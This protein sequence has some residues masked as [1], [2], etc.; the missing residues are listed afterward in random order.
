MAAHGTVP[1]APQA[2]SST[3][4][5]LGI[6]FHDEGDGDEDATALE[7][8]SAEDF[9]QMIDSAEATIQEQTLTDEDLAKLLDQHATLEPTSSARSRSAPSQNGVPGSGHGPRGVEEAMLDTVALDHSPPRQAQHRDGTGA[10]DGK[11]QRARDVEA[12]SGSGKP[13]QQV[14]PPP[15]ELRQPTAKQQQQQQQPPPRYSQMQQ[16]RRSTLDGPRTVGERGD[17]GD[18]LQDLADAFDAGTDAVMELFDEVKQNLAEYNALE[19]T[20]VFGKSD[21]RLGMR[22]ERRPTD[23]ACEVTFV[24]QDMAA[25][26]LGLQVDDI[27]VAVN[28]RPTPTFDHAM[29]FLSHRPPIRPLYVTLRRPQQIN[30]PLHFGMR[31]EIAKAARIVSAISGAPDTEIMVDLMRK[32]V[33]FA[34]LTTVKIGGGISGMGGG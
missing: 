15:V 19:L 7:S 21:D 10:A 27:V 13:G 31:D 17:G 8:F 20:V 12:A 29:R 3:A 34:F 33:G 6:D 28:G 30:S 22:V 1:R 25:Q 5:L 23:Y 9:Q 4:A 14:P 2:A 18:F 24:E 11:D 32:A 26:R 16:A